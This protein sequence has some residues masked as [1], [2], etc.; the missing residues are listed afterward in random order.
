MFLNIYSTP[1]KKNNFE[2]N[3]KELSLA[4]HHH[5]LFPPHPPLTKKSHLLT[6]MLLFSIPLMKQWGKVDKAALHQLIV[7]GRVNIE[8]LSF[9]NIN[10]V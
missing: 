7:E 4:C 2:H 8:D 9:D 6:L 5:D 3:R 10:A 1:I